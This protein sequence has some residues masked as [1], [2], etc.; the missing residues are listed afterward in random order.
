MVVTKI[1]NPTAH[2]PNPHDIVKPYLN[3]NRYAY[4]E[5]VDY[6]YYLLQ[7][8]KLRKGLQKTL[9]TRLRDA[10]PLNKKK[11]KIQ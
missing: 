5:V 10:H 6:Y 7:P 1:G 3:N 8:G 9:P 4:E 2:L 11:M